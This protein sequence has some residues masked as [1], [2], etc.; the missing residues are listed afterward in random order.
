MTQP[1]EGAR[2]CHDL[3]PGFR[4]APFGSRQ[5]GYTLYENRLSKVFLGVIGMERSYGG[6]LPECKGTAFGTYYNLE[7]TLEIIDMCQK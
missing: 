6:A 7:N 4:V 1:H 3:G 5:H 2:A